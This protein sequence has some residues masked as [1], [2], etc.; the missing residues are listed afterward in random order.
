MVIKRIG[1]RNWARGLAVAALVVV[2]PVAALYG[3]RSYRSFVLLRS[4]YDVDAPQ[5]SS[6]RGWMTLGYVAATYHVPQAVLARRLGLDGIADA[7]T[8]LKSLGAREGLSPSQYVQRVQRAI[9]ETPANKS[10]N[11]SASTT[12]WLTQ[13]RDAVLTALIVYGYPVLAAIL[14]LAAF[15]LPLPDAVAM[16][17]AGSLIAQHHMSWLSAGTT[18]V[19]ASTLGDVVGYGFGRL[20]G[21]ELLERRGRWIGY[22]VSRLARARRLFDRWGALTVLLSRR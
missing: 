15:G 18:A 12:G 7:N 14:L 19:L 20:I 13:I 3:L 2:V 10:V 8:R 17:V 16:A 21:R 22:T 1:R 11:H 6:V 9:A 4:A 5:T